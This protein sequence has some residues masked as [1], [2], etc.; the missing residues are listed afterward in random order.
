MA[1]SD[2][3]K[4]HAETNQ[5]HGLAMVLKNEWIAENADKKA[6]DWNPRAH[7][8]DMKKRYKVEWID[9]QPRFKFAARV[10]PQIAP[11][12]FQGRKHIEIEFLTVE[13]EDKAISHIRTCDVGNV[14][15]V[16][17]VSLDFKYLWLKPW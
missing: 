3:S 16:D 7:L 17:T 5:N 10:K 8:K 14:F 15:L 12:P 4:R 13:A 2:D 1:N 9:D 6:T 11:K